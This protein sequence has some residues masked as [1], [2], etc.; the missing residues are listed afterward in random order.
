VDG[1]HTV[2]TSRALVGDGVY[3]FKY[4]KLLAMNINHAQHQNVQLLNALKDGFRTHAFK[5]T[6]ENCQYSKTPTSLYLAVAE[7]SHRSHHSC[8]TAETRGLP[9][10]SRARRERRIDQQFLKRRVRERGQKTARGP[11]SWTCT[12]LGHVLPSLGARFSLPAPILPLVSALTHFNG[13][14]TINLAGL[15]GVM[16]DDTC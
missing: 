15:G 7:G 10:N 4:D 9:L 3:D 6:I 1:K 5:L 16:Y 11:A 13:A 8:T 12:D 14:T 2:S